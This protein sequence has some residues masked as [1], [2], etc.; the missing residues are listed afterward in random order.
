[1]AENAPPR[2]AAEPA[3]GGEQPNLKLQIKQTCS[4]NGDVL[5][6]KK[7]KVVDEKNGDNEK[8]GGDEVNSCTERFNLDATLEEL[9]SFKEG[10]CPENTPKSTKWALHNLEKCS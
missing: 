3:P 1:M 7:A 2:G 10:I 4:K 5:S 6:K 9:D 8:N